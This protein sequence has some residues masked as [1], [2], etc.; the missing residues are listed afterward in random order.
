MADRGCQRR[1]ASSR[2]L[3]AQALQRAVSRQ[4]AIARL[5]RPLA[6]G[7]PDQPDLVRRQ[8]R[9]V[10]SAHSLGTAVLR[11]SGLWSAKGR[12]TLL[13][14]AIPHSIYGLSDQRSANGAWR[15]ARHMVRN[16]AVLRRLGERAGHRGGEMAADAMEL[17]AEPVDCAARRFGR[18]TQGASACGPAR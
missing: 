15:T 16:A 10:G 6:A 4:I 3:R 7:P 11:R 14:S 9:R 12:T 1:T 8:R 2:L 13:G 17:L 18:A 5:T